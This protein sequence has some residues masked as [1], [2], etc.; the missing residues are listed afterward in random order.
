M[1]LAVLEWHQALLKE[2]YETHRPEKENLIA[3]PI[4]L[5]EGQDEEALKGVIVKIGDFGILD[6]DRQ[7]AIFVEAER[8]HKFTKTKVTYCRR[9]SICIISRLLR[10]HRAFAYPRRFLRHRPRL[11]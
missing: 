7:Y 1:T 11:T 10:Q 4:V 2:G 8:V 3:W 5:E 9:Q 6:K